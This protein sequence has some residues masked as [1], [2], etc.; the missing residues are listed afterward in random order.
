MAEPTRTRSPTTLV[1]APLPEELAALV[2][3]LTGM[4]ILGKIQGQP[5]RTGQLRGRDVSLGVCGD[6]PTRSR[7]GL[8]ALLDA[9][10]VEQ[11]V[12]VGVAGGLAPDLEV[13]TLVAGEQVRDEKGWNAAPKASLLATLPP[14]VTRGV[15]VSTGR[16]VVDRAGKRR[17]W[18]QHTGS[19]PAAV[20]D[21]E[22]AAL[23]RVAE[24][25]NLPWLVIRAVSDRA[26]ESLPP[27]LRTCV[28][29]DGSTHRGQVALQALL[30]PWHIPGLWRLAARVR[31]CSQR[32]ADAVESV[33][34]L[35]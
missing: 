32:L 34:A 24:E 12:I 30:H 3:R 26:G 16:L 19:A 21:L 31:H 4:R 27:F 25:R 29:A 1:V 13:G 9:G 22:S 20:V 17:L 5:L 28:R 7:T 2:A 15:V 23:V 6:G 11:V 33:L 35:T 8:Q 10:L 18:E 14:S